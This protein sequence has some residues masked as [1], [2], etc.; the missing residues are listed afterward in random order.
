M[1]IRMHGGMI[2]RL[3]HDKQHASQKLRVLLQFLFSPLLISFPVFFCSTLLHD[4]PHFHAVLSVYLKIGSGDDA[5]GEGGEEGRGE[6]VR[7]DGSWLLVVGCR[8]LIVEC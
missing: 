8:F 7:T 4:A 2:D 5:N 1:N 6:G 3:N